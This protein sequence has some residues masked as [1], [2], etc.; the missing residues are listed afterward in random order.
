MKNEVIYN[1]EDRKTKK[2]ASMKRK[3]F[4]GTIGANLLIAVLAIIWLLPMVYIILRSFDANTALN[5][6]NI[7]PQ[8]WTLDNYVNLFTDDTQPY[9]QWL[10]N[11]LILAVLNCVLSTFFTL[12]TAFSLSRFRFKS[13]KPL[14]NISLIL[15]M[16]PGFMS[17]TAIYLLLDM[18]GRMIGYH[19]DGEIVSLLLIWVCGSGLGFFVSKGYFDTIPNAIEEAAMVEGANMFTVF[20]KIFLPMAKPIIIYTAL[21]AFMVPWSDFVLS[22]IILGGNTP[23]ENYTVA[24]GLYRMLENENT[25]NE[26]FT[27]FIAGCVLEA[28]PIVILYISLQKFM[29]Q[30]IA[31]GAVKG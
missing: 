26:V 1:L 5:T 19:L 2:Y 9:A 15:G 10:I 21:T 8:E 3:R 14:M 24:V 7:I 12:V 13:R 6:S 31:A 16:F 27:K 29:V 18:F 20:F 4:Y 28:V 25:I 17:M 11:T 30:G 23:V 22:G